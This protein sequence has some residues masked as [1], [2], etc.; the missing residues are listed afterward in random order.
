[1]SEQAMKF[2][3]EKLAYDLIPPE[4]LHALAT[5]LTYGAKK[6]APRNWERGLKFRRIF[7]ALQRH[8]WAWQGGED[9]DPESGIEH[10][11]HALCNLSFLVA[12]TAQDRYELDDRPSHGN[13]TSTEEME[14]YSAALEPIK[15]QKLPILKGSDMEVR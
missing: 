7:A 8:L 12:Y 5:V 4:A 6:Y 10:L 14:A 3:K 11:S 2:D 15:N 9:I 1:M 13:A